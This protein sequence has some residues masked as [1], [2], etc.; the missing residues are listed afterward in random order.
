MSIIPIHSRTFEGP[1]LIY[2][3]YF[4]YRIMRI[5]IFIEHA[6]HEVF[7]KEAAILKQFYKDTIAEYDLD[8]E[9]FTYTN[10][11]LPDIKIQDNDIMIPGDPLN[12][13]GKRSYLVMSYIQ[14]YV[15]CDYIVKTNT[16]T[17]L[18][19]K[20][21][22]EFCNSK[23]FQKT[24][25]FYTMWNHALYHPNVSESGYI[26]YLLGKMYL[27]P[28]QFLSDII[29]VWDEATVKGAEIWNT[30]WGCPPTDDIIMTAAYNILKFPIEKMYGRFM[31]LYGYDNGLY[32]PKFNDDIKKCISYVVKMPF[33]GNMNGIQ[34]INIDE[35]DMRTMMEIPVLE[36]TIDIIKSI[37]KYM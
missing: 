21:L 31:G 17:V 22:S 19:L 35:K 16:S 7:H 11:D 24:L 1:F 34:A 27:Y 26:E 6:G 25:K 20:A 5:S 4:I 13:W 9:V 32:H 8:M 18:N 23:S 36:Y 29:R 30:C 10:S 14:D 37:Q 2:K 33:S 28:K 12:D 15:D 3:R